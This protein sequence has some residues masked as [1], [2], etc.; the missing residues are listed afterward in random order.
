MVQVRPPQQGRP[1][2]R[3]LRVERDRSPSRAAKDV[4]FPDQEDSIWELDPKTN[5]WYLHHFYKHQPDLNIANPKVQEEIS[6]TLGFWLELGVSG[7]RVDAVPFLFA[8]DAAPGEPGRVRPH[9]VPRRRPQLRHP[10]GR[11]RRPARRGQPSLQGPEGVLRR[12]RRRRAQHAV[13]LHR[14]AEH[15]PVTR[16]RRRPPDRQGAAAATGA[17]RDEPVGQL[18]AQPRRAHPRQAERRRAPGGFRRL[19]PRPGHAALRPRTAPT[20]PVHARRRR[21][22]DADGLLAGLLPAGHSGPLLRRGDRDGREP[23]HPRTTRRAHADAVDRRPT[24]AASPR[25]RSGGSPARFPTA[26]TGR[27]ASTPPT[28]ATTTTPSG[29]SCA[30]SSTPTGSS[31]RSAGRRSRSSSSPT[32]AVLAHVC[33]EE[34]GWAM[35]ALHNFGADSCHRARFSSRTCRRVPSSS[36]CSTASSEHELDAEGRVEIDLEPYGYRWLRLRRPEDEP[37]I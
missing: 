23:R 19:R 29:G 6:R 32:R 30:T 3:L 20:A 21:A 12:P 31:R 2:P 25:R 36:T 11:G 26:S 27:S 9:P 35:V 7:F 34:S 28:S 14:D 1:V 5:E 22:A 18:R 16:P 4:V 24:T 8:K 15:L 10:P 33:R 17:R 13:R 37:I